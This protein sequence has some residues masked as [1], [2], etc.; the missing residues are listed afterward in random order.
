MGYQILS[1]LV[2]MHAVISGSMATVEE[3]S[4]AVKPK[5][6]VETAAGDESLS[7]LVAAVKAADLVDALNGEGPFT[8]F[9]PTNEA[10]DALPKG[11]VKSLLKP[12]NKKKL[13]AI[14]KYHVV[15]GKLMAED[16]VKLD[17]AETLQGQV[18]EIE[19]ADAGVTVGNGKLTKTDAVCSN[20]V[21]HVIDKV[22]L[23]E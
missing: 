4:D 21:I 10:F 8:L 16:V 1:L 17:S 5:T 14:L 18:A 11:T 15:P 12:E 13:Q 6:V 19:V 23:P 20:G 3:A 7:T 22:I 9:A 2:L